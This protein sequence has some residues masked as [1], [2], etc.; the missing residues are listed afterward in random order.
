[1]ST[2][3]AP[4]VREFILAFADDEHLMGQQHTE[5][6]G[7]TPFLEE[8]LAFAS[9]GQD[10]LGH[11]ALLYALL[12]GDD[13]AAIDELAFFRPH[14][15]YRCCW[16]VER[17]GDDWA[18]ALVRHWM[19]DVAEEHRWDLVA[20]S[21][22][23]ALAD[24]SV[25]ARREETFHRRHADSLL[26]ALL[27]DNDA[28]DRLVA[29]RDRLVGLALGMF[30]RTAAE[31]DAVAAGV[32]S[33]PLASRIDAWKAAVDNRFGPTDWDAARAPA[34]NGRRA[35]SADFAALHSRVREVFDLD[36]TATW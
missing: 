4:G 23:R 27:T 17:A 34:Q 3:I 33:A 21:S 26:D 24:A 20:D 14:D 28:R 12:V 1:M 35:R 22:L 15:E 9:I 19:Y 25:L 32:A 13:D 7:V 16:L 6:I 2:D 31:Q 18:D 5:W 29:A 11:A 30:E 10:E 36:H 8:D